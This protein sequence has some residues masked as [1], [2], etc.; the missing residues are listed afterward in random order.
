MES[1][2]NCFRHVLRILKNKTSIGLV[3]IWNWCAKSFVKVADFYEHR[4]SVDFVQG[5]YEKGRRLCR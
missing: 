3:W 1:E 4:Q 2:K 5:L